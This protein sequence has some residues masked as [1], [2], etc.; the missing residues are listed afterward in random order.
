[1]TAAQ[2]L[3]RIKAGQFV[4]DQEKAWLIANHLPSRF[5]F[6]IDNNPGIINAMLR[7]QGYDHLG[8]MA[9]KTAIASQLNM[10]IAN[11]DVDGIKKILDG[12]VLMPDGLTPQ[13]VE[14]IKQ[15]LGVVK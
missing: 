15:N 4:T 6:M 11:K 3:A 10:M 2:I 1:M 5:A 9:D 8:F 12:F 14:L 7:A 13:F